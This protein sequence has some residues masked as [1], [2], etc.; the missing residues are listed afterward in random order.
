MSTYFTL[1]YEKLTNAIEKSKLNTCL[2]MIL[3]SSGFL[4]HYQD[5]PFFLRVLDLFTNIHPSTH[6]GKGTLPF[7]PTHKHKGTFPYLPTCTHSFTNIHSFTYLD[8]QTRQII[9][10]NS[11]AASH[12]CDIW[13]ILVGI[14]NSQ[15]FPGHTSCFSIGLPA[16]L[17]HQ[18][19]EGTL[20]H[21]N[22]PILFLRIYLRLLN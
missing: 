6:T 8:T 12:I 20:F 22:L 3:Y 18:E 5:W 9:S 7:L 16:T 4:Y 15:Y 10:I 21:I 17:T 2:R 13:D 14:T 19:A 11:S 1:L